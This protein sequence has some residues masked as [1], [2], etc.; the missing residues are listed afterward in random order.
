MRL[1]IQSIFVPLLAMKRKCLL[2]IWLEN[3]WIWPGLWL[4]IIV[5]VFYYA[6]LMEEVD[7]SNIP[8]ILADR[9]NGTLTIDQF[10]V[11]FIRV[12]DEYIK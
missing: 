6:L 9:L 2:E 3:I 8:K 12:M 7:K 1:I 11:T 10:A 5:I 4:I